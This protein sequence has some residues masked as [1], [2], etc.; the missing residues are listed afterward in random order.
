LKEKLPKTKE[1]IRLVDLGVLEYS[2]ECASILPEFS[3]LMKNGKIKIVTCFRKFN[4]L[5]KPHQFSIPKI[6]WIINSMEGFSKT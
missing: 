2:Y 3:N 4:L 5:L 1:I 6:G